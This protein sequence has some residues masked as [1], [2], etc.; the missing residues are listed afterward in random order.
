MTKG[1]PMGLIL[2]FAL[3]LLL[4]NLLQQLYNVAD[5][6]IVGRFL[7]ADALAAVGAT[8]SVQ[9]LILG[10]CIGT[11]TGF[12]V[13]VAQK[14]GAKDYAH[15]RRLV[16]NSVLLTAIGAVVITIL[17]A[18]LCPQI[19]R[20]LSTPENIWNDTYIYILII[21]LGIPFTLLYNLAAGIL[22]AVGDSRTPFLF[23]A[24]SA[25]ANIFLDLFCIAVLGWG[26]AGAAI[27]TITSQALSGVLCTRVILK[28]YEILHLNAEDRRI[29]AADN[30]LLL[31]M[32]L[33]MGMQFS[34]TAI[35]SMVMQSANNGLGSMYASAFTAA[36]RIKMFAMCPF[37]AIAT[38]VAT[39][40]SQNYGAGESE[41]IHTGYR[42]GCAA[43]FLYGLLIG[44]GLIFFG[45]T[46]CLI[47]LS[48]SEHEIL[49]AAALY[50]RQSG[51]FFCTL[52]LLN[53]NRITVQGLGFSGRAVLSGV[54]EMFARI[55]VALILVPKYGFAAICIADPA[56]WIAADVYI[57]PTCLYILHKVSRMLPK[58]GE[59]TAPAL[60]YRQHKLKPSHS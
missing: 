13:P 18:L 10:F 45:R 59:N 15:M 34:I 20:I 41:R 60:A 54:M 6:S 43:S 42:I 3:P 22:R 29:H 27:A 9:F 23:L 19:L 11:C 47:F 52:G 49:D 46:A 37:D 58:K 40:C 24:F 4:G 14:F 25:V 39:F 26:C 28:K 56:A 1:R 32:G 44:T 7:G 5:A 17:C 12:C 30:R 50:L 35:G 16:Y 38:G 21:F 33:P 48:S 51:Y 57:I 36:A 2:R 31:M 8:S 53:V 55:A